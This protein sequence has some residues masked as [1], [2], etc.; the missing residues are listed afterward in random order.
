MVRIDIYNYT[1]QLIRTIS[2]GV[3]SKGDHTVGFD[4]GGLGNGVY[5]YTLNI[6][7]QVVDTGKMT[8]VK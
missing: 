5:F 8:V 2:E 4:A 1:G 3:K 6:N 7:G